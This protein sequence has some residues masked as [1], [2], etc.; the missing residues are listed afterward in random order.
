MSVRDL[1]VG[2]RL[3]LLHMSDPYDPIPAGATG[4][5]DCPPV[6]FQGAVQVGVK[7]DPPNERRSLSVV[8]PPDS[9]R[10]LPSPECQPEHFA[11]HH[12]QWPEEDYGGA[13][14]GMGNVY[15]DADPGL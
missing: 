8:C 7:W 11:S 6:E 14:G 12:H 15:P 2:D 5:V 13:V 3:E 4:V 1:K 10:R 9:V